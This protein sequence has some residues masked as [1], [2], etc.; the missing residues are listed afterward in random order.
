MSWLR[1]VQLYNDG[2]LPIS[3]HLRKSR[4]ETCGENPIQKRSRPFKKLIINSLKFWVIR[5]DAFVF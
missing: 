5:V 1:Y 3:F 2:N 4:M